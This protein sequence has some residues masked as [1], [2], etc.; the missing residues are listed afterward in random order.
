VRNKTKEGQQTMFVKLENGDYLNLDMVSR[1]NIV[2][3]DT[4]PADK[5]Y[6][7]YVIIPQGQPLTVACFQFEEEARAF[8]KRLVTPESGIQPKE[9][10]E[11]PDGRFCTVDAAATISGYAKNTICGWCKKGIVEAVKV[12]QDDGRSVWMIDKEK[13]SR[14]LSKNTQEKVVYFEKLRNRINEKF[15][16]LT[17]FSKYIYGKNS[18]VVFDKLSKRVPFTNPDIQRWSWGLE[19]SKDE[20]PEYFYPDDTAQS[21]PQAEDSL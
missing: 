19:I 7:V 21:S 9:T 8:I 15:G 2:S 18:T 16:T 4:T 20:V 10:A 3:M 6:Q 5:K 14:F 11:N 12:T 17:A 13:F 1:I